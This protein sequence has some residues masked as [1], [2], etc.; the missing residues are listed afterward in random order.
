MHQSSPLNSRQDGTRINPDALNNNKYSLRGQSKKRFTRSRAA[1]LSSQ[2]SGDSA[3]YSQMT[4]I[5]R[6]QPGGHESPFYREEE[7]KIA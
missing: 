6:R 4:N 1:D 3:L 2:A 7:P 5:L